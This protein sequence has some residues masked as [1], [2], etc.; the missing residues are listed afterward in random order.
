VT[1]YTLDNTNQLL[2]ADHTGQT[3]ESYSYDVN[4]NRTMSG[5]STTTKNRPSSD[6]TYN[7]TYDDEGNRLT[8]TNIATGAKEEYTWDW[9]NRLTKIKFKDSG[10]NVPKT[11]DQTDDF[12]NQWIR[13]SVDS[14][15]PGPEAA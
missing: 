5:Y 1:N 12:Q 2:A 10:G 3:D 4:G 6:G 11:V 14:D 15:G 13:R 9:R 7:Y 8:R